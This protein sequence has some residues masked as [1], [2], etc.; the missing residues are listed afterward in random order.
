MNCLVMRRKLI[1]HRRLTLS[2]GE[3][4]AGTS[5]WVIEPCGVPL[6]SDA[7]RAVGQCRSCATGWTHPENYKVSP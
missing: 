3:V 2:S 5:E 6:F 1:R 7:E 4:T